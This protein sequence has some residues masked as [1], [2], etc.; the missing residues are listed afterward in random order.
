MRSEVDSLFFEMNW[1]F[2]LIREGGEVL[3]EKDKLRLVSTWV[4]LW[5]RVLPCE[6]EAVPRSKSIYDLIAYDFPRFHPG[7]S[8]SKLE[9][10]KKF[11]QA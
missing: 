7:G 2:G 9:R 10:Y 11:F 6:E 3:F 8:L 5:R 4:Q 1:N